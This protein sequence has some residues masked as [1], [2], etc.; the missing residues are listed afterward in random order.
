MKDGTIQRGTPDNASGGSSTR[1]VDVPQRYDEWTLLLAHFPVPTRAVRSWIP[2][3]ALVPLEYVPGTAV[4]TLAAFEYL[5]P[6]TLAPYNE[7]AIAVPVRPVLNDRGA[8]ASLFQTGAS[9]LGFWVHLLP[10]TTAESRDV[11]VSVWGLPKVVARI[12][13]KELHWARRVSLIEGNKPVLTLQAPTGPTREVSQQFTIYSILH[14]ALVRSRIEAHG[15]LYAWDT[16]GQASFELGE[17]P[18]ADELRAM[19]L[20]NFAVAGMYGVGLRGTLFGP[21]LGVR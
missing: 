6:A 17:H 7:V 4:V 18:I 9:G 2:A 11:G 21:E 12:D 13:F 19:K 16:A 20:R 5:R 1:A 15:P 14:G 10:V 8:Y 3:D